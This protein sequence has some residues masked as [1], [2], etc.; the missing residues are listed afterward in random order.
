MDTLSTESSIKIMCLYFA[1]LK[2]TDSRRRGITNRYKELELISG[3]NA[4]TIRQWTDIFDPHFDNGRSGYHQKS[5]KEQNLSLYHLYLEY[6]NKSIN[7]MEQIVESLNNDLVGSISNQISVNG[8]KQR[9]YSVKTSDDNIVMNILDGQSKIEI[10][11]LNWFEDEI[12]TN[13]IV[14]IVISGDKKSWANGLICFGH[15]TRTPFDK[16]Y[17]L[18][19][20]KNFKI[21]VTI[22][23]LFPRELS[24]SYFYYYP[25]TRNVINIGPSTKGTPN[26][27]INRVSERGC[28]SILRGIIDEFPNIEKQ[29]Q[30]TFGQKALDSAKGNIPKFDVPSEQLK[31]IELADL[32]YDFEGSEDLIDITDLTENSLKIL[33]NKLIIEEEISPLNLELMMD[34]QVQQK[35][36]IQISREQPS[37][38]DLVRKYDRFITY[39]KTTSEDDYSSLESSII[40]SPDFQREFVWAK[41]KQRELIESILLGIPLPIFYFSEDING[42]F[43][44][45]DG[46]QRLNAIFSFINKEF[47]LD[48]KMRFLCLDK[49]NNEDV[50][51][52][53]LE[54][55]IQRKIEDFTLLCYIVSS[56]T[57]ASIQNE[58][59]I[60]VNRGGVRLNDQEIRNATNIGKVTNK[61]LN[62]I[63]NNKALDLVPKTRKRDQYIALRFIA[64]YLS[65]KDHIFNLNFNFDHDYQNMND[66]LDKTMKYLNSKTD[67]FIKE[68]YDVYQSSFRKSSLIFEEGNLKLFSRY[69]SNSVNMT[70]FE[71]WMLLM[72]YYSENE[73]ANN[74]NFFINE[75]NTMIITEDFLKNILSLRDNKDRIKYRINY[76][77]K[78]NI[79]FQENIND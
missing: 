19:K 3:I 64:I 46:K 59:F 18:S 56:S 72:S 58:I 48:K 60:R 53:D 5:I 40:L 52:S 16:G 32:G 44:V 74:L 49:K 54:P 65:K 15:I 43:I 55:K 33:N 76:I 25:N 63:S 10:D 66:F 11:R 71:V 29:I 9:L 57:P 69:N 77:D 36:K 17:M 8:N 12:K 7:E 39:C 73:I 47:E 21:E 26:Q 2:S 62:L 67:V 41:Q 1:M 20:P 35:S 4:N 27:A 75:Y 14:F 37:V 24:Q 38:Y 22:D 23:S 28:L 30:S 13:D 61:L 31:K 78:I 51:F 68:I 34:S 79:K 50:S 70:I 42:N 45:V 6:K